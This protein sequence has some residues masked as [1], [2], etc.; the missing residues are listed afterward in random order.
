MPIKQMV[1]YSMVP[2]TAAS[3]V[4]IIVTTG[5]TKIRSATVRTT[6]RHINSVTV[7]PIPEAAFSL[8]PAPTACPMETVDPMASP[9]IMTV[10]ICITWE[11]MDTAVVLATPS[12]W[13]MINRSAIP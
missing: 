12:N 7:L 3:G 1:R 4:D 8:S 2:D 11:P 13:P 5:R 10:S 6:D 9:T